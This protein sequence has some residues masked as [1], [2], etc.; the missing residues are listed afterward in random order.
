MTDP[1]PP[2][3]PGFASLLT[4]DAISGM[5]LAIAASFV[6]ALQAGVKWI[7]VVTS[8]IA[9]AILTGVTLPLAA[10]NGYTWAD[11]LGVVCVMNGVLAG[12][13]FM[14]IAI[15]GRRA[16]ARGEAIADNV[17]DRVMGPGDK[18]P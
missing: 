2:P 3:S 1:V 14:L 7:G 4:P 15:L 11:W 16:L 8:S 13:V 17:L 9:A 6:A 18:K 10:K 5:A 12:T